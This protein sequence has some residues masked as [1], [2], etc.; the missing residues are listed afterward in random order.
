MLSDKKTTPGMVHS[1]YWFSM[2]EIF[3]PV[4]WNGFWVPFAI[5]DHWIFGRWIFFKKSRG[6]SELNFK[7]GIL[8]FLFAWFSVVTDFYPVQQRQEDCHKTGVKISFWEEERN[9]KYAQ[10]RQR[11][12]SELLFFPYSIRKSLKELCR[13]QNWFLCPKYLWSNLFP[14]VCI[15]LVKGERGVIWVQCWA[16]LNCMRTERMLGYWTIWIYTGGKFL[17]GM[18]MQISFSWP[19]ISASVVEIFE[20]QHFIK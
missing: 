11:C 4:T 5:V 17:K 18:M 13:K 14:S 1:S 6:C 7:T 2:R 12:P 20:T 16:L 3:D 15:S 10:L 8:S 19:R 9:P